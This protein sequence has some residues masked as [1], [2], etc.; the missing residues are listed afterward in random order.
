[1]Y[2]QLLLNVAYTI[3]LNVNMTIIKTVYKFYH[4]TLKNLILF[5]SWIAMESIV[6]KL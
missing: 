3:P 4:Y 1:M 5:M 2:F 6:L